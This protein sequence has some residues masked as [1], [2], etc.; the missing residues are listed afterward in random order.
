[1]LYSAGK[2]A[3]KAWGGSKRTFGNSDRA[4]AIS[5]DAVAAAKA[6]HP[7]GSDHMN[8]RRVSPFSSSGAGAAAAA[9]GAAG[10]A[11]GREGGGGAAGGVAP[12][13]LDASLASDMGASPGLD[14]I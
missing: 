14:V 9:G 2:P 6:T 1:M 4:V 10:A 5:P 8:R 7:T 13:G 11:A 3:L 12:A